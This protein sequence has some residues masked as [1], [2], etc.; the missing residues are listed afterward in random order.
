MHAGETSG[1]AAHQDLE[2]QMA[3]IDADRGRS[4]WACRT[5]HPLDLGVAH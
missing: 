3:Q 5:H 4:V 1:I 2:P